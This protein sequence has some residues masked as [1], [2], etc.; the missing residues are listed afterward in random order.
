MPEFLAKREGFEN[1]RKYQPRIVV[2]EDGGESDED[3][4]HWTNSNETEDTPD[5]H[6]TMI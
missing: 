5:C 2:D 3:E 6:L 1:E 4:M